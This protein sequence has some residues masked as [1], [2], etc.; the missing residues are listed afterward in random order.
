MAE[1]PEER[2]DQP[3]MLGNLTFLLALA[4]TSARHRVDE[5]LSAHGIG[6]RGL[7]ILAHV[8]AEPD[9]S[10]SA[11][12]RRS[13]VTVQTM[14]ASIKTL[15]DA[16]LV[17]RRSAT[18]PGQAVRLVLTDRGRQTLA[19]ADESITALP[20][21]WLPLDRDEQRRLSSLLGK[22]VRAT[23]ERAG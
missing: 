13:N 21:D 10:Y 16:G 20:A 8:D 5:V 7:G 6:M 12:A 9:L 19:A 17:A 14:T 11:L 2:S 15:Q 23:V 4:G 1:L 18:R 3:A 22:V